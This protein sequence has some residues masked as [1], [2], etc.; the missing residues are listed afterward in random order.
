M[1][2]VLKKQALEQLHL[3]HMGIEKPK[4]L[5]RESVYW[6]NIY[7][8]IE[9]NINNCTTCLMCQQT[10]LKNNI[11]CHDIPARPWEIAGADMF[12]LNNQHYLCIVDYHS[13][14]PVI[15]KSENLS[16]DSHILTCKFIFAEYWLPKKIMLDLG[17]NFI[18][19]KFKTFCKSLNIEQT[20]SSLYHH[21]NN[22]QVE[23]CIRVIKHTLKKV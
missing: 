21:Q 11:I 6:I 20:F 10:Q 12:T 2:K 15:K 17:G 23:A 22:G 14:F 3:N 1:P 16:A 9:K 8:N 7:D 19:D 18:S 4:L 13:K 5:V